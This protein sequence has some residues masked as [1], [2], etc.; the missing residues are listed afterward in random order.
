[1]APSRIAVLGSA[2]GGSGMLTSACRSSGMTVRC[3]EPLVEEEE[4]VCPSLGSAS[5]LTLVTALFVSSR[6]SSPKGSP[7]LLLL[8]ALLAMRSQ[9]DEF[10][11]VFVF[12]K[13]GEQ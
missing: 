4:A 8:L 12:R 11:L 1:M 13:T 10:A 3:C 7:P 2:L 6:G 5:L 9:V